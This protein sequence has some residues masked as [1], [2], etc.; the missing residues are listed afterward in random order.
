MTHFIHSC[1]GVNSY[2]QILDREIFEINLNLP[3]GL[4][5]MVLEADKRLYLGSVFQPA[6]SDLNVFDLLLQ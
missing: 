6:D 4:A 1:V 3:L 5:Y 2:S